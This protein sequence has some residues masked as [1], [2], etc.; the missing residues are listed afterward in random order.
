[1]DT[2]T[3][4][5]DERSFLLYVETCCVDGGGLLVGV[6]MNAE[7]HAAAA[8]FVEAGLLASFGRI[9]SALLG[10]SGSPQGA[11]HYAELTDAGWLL[12]HTLRRE[13]AKR[14]G[15]YATSV[16][17]HELVRDRTERQQKGRATCVAG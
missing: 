15:P 17:D 6:R 1:M 10:R 3:L 12:A 14:R 11:T 5:K 13:R 9:P 16:F 2:G 7:D 8:K 4:T